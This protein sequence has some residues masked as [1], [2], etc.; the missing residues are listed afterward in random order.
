[1]LKNYLNAMSKNPKTKIMVFGTFDVIH[2]GHLHFFTQAR[3]LTKNPLLVVSVARDKNVRRIKGRL[4]LQ[5]ERQRLANIKKIKLVDK[6]VLGGVSS[7]LPHIIKEAPAIIALGYDQNTYT[8]NLK[9]ELLKNGLSV[10]IV[11]LKPHKPN[12]YKSSLMKEKVKFAIFDI[13][14]TL[15]RSS[16]V[17]QLILELVKKEVFPE[18]VL[19]IME[20]DYLAWLNR[21]GSYENYINQIVKIYY[22]SIRGS[23]KT[24]IDSAVR[25]VLTVQK[26]RVYRYTRDLIRKLKKDHYLLTISGSPLDIVQPFADYFGFD[27]AF[28][29]V[30]EVKGGKFTGRVANDRIMNSRKD[31]IVKD[32]LR[33]NQLSVDWKNSYAVGDTETEIPLLKL[34]GNPI[35]FNPNVNLAKYATK[36]NWQIVV[37]RKDVI[38]QIDKFK[39]LI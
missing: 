33:K 28:G 11:K 29:R 39:F 15:F 19:D 4:P 24:D 34:V 20:E 35:A 25:H 5:K 9:N 32:F 17:I 37:E 6:A 21:H 12:K 14:G 10:K 30:F 7:Y 16:L 22:T 36:H 31:K 2:P 38:Y 1:M 13:D 8:K 26:D 23:R 18:E 3:S 27:T